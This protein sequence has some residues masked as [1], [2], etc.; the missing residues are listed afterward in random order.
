MA[1]SFLHS[2]IS[3]SAAGS[4]TKP[5]FIGSTSS[6]DDMYA[7]HTQ[8][9]N[10]WTRAV[11]AQESH[12]EEAA[13]LILMTVAIIGI[14]QYMSHFLSKASILAMVIIPTA[15]CIRIAHDV[16]FLW[17]VCSCLHRMI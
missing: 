3:H 13:I 6:T 9:E 12:F 7:S 5:P 1:Y 14:F 4:S 17:M 8:F 10:K 15:F 16:L 2:M 11:S